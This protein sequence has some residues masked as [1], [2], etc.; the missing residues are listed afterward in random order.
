VKEKMIRRVG[1]VKVECYKCGEREHKYREYLL[2]ERKKGGIC[3]EAAKGTPTEGASMPCKEKSARRKK[4]VEEDRERRGSI[5]G[6]ATRSAI[7]VKEELGGRVEKES[8]GTLW[9]RST[10]GSICKG[11]TL[12][13]G[14]VT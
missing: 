1:V 6:Q 3:S 7:R 14:L 2:W 10:R 13:L 12:G 4:E 9:Q 11:T 8:R 5:H